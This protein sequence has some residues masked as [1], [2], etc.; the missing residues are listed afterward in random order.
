M[1][2]ELDI[3]PRTTYL[4]KR[5]ES[6]S[7]VDIMSPIAEPAKIRTLHRDRIRRLVRSDTAFHDVTEQ[8]SSIIE[9]DVLKTPTEVLDRAGHHRSDSVLLG[10]C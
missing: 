1:L 4:A 7:G 8:I 5:A 2:A 9:G 3:R 10:A 6:Q